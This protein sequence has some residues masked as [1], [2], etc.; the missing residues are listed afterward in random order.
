MTAEVIER[1]NQLLERL[2]DV[3]AR[4]PTFPPGTVGNAEFMTGPHYPTKVSFHFDPPLTDNVRTRLNA[5]GRWINEATVVFLVATLRAHDVVKE[6]LSEREGLD[7]VE[8]VRIAKKLRH[9]LLKEGG[10]YKADKAEHRHVM[11]TLVKLYG[12]PSSDTEYPLDID[13]ILIPMIEGCQRY[14]KACAA[15]SS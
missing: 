5:A 3:R 13:K 2:H 9:I 10:A 7:G 1:L 4:V 14:A 11:A 12:V 6:N 8:H 15:T